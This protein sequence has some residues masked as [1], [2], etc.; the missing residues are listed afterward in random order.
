MDAN[1][2][3]MSEKRRIITISRQMGS[4]GREVGRL[5]A[6]LLGYQFVSR[7]IINQ[8]AQRAGSPEAALAAI[9]ELGLLGLCP[10]EKDCQ[11][12]IEAVNTVIQ[13]LAEEGGIVILGRA[14]QAILSDRP[15]VLHVR[16]IAPAVLRAERVAGQ[17]GISLAGAAAQ[18]EASD[19][20]R[21]NYLRR[22]YQQKWDDPNLYDLTINTARIS[23][24]EA[25]GLIYQAAVTEAKTNA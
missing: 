16:V 22:Y 10:S 15:D 2:N 23:P 7:E 12:Y 18:V 17:Q 5:A 1:S 21:R 24:S 9:D 6:E 13:E 8:A 14:G 19:R 11:A 3:T 4:A 25:A 20:Y